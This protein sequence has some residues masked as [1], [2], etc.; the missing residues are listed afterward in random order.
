VRKK[1]PR[2]PAREVRNPATGEMI[3]VG[4]KPAGKKLVFRVSKAAKQAAKI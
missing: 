1:T 3:K 4:P 2:K